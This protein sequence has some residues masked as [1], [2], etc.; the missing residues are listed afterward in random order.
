MNVKQA[1]LC[2]L[3]TLLTVGAKA[4]ITNEKEKPSFFKSVDFHV[5]AGFSI[6]GSAPIPFPVEI[7]QIE[8]YNPTLSLGLGAGLTK[9]LG[10]QKLWG[11]R[12]GLHVE[13]KGMKTTAQVKNY[14]TEVIGQGGQKV[15][16]NFTG[17]VQT[18]AKNS[19]FTLPLLVTYG[20]LE[21][22]NFYAG[23]YFSALIEKNFTGY[24]YDGYLREGG[25]TGTKIVFSGDNK[26]P[27]DFSQDLNLFQ[28]GVMAGAEWRLRRHLNLFGELSWGFNNLFERDFKTITFDMHSIY[29]SIGLGY[30]F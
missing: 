18:N 25:P 14:F 12:T 16:G 26:G 28:W 5:R 30:T 24:V 21:N 22:W 4:Q 2:S 29:L 11:I 15:T 6:G 20:A 3:L 9:W 27:Y 10:E 13:G 19:Y 23:P 8:H 17:M 7:R 1:I